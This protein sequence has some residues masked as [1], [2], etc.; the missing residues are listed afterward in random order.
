MPNSWA[1][2]NNRKMATRS[3]QYRSTKQTAMALVSRRILV[4]IVCFRLTTK[5]DKLLWI[6]RLLFRVVLLMWIQMCTLQASQHN[7]LR[8]FT[9]LDKTQLAFLKWLVYRIWSNHPIWTIAT[10]WCTPSRIWVRCLGPRIWGSALGSPSSFP[11]HTRSP[12][13]IPQ[14]QFERPGMSAGTRSWGLGLS[15]V[16]KNN[17]K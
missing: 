8:L 7:H 6:M 14:S 2:C 9:K 16:L 11:A 13:L 1:N 3:I 17:V 12:R 5:N 15:R 10:D 4:R